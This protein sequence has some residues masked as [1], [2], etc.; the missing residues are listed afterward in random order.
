MAKFKKV[1]LEDMVQIASNISE[2]GQAVGIIFQN[3]EIS[4]GGYKRG[5]LVTTRVVSITIPI[6]ESDTDILV[7]QD[8]RGSVSVDQGAR[9]ILVAHLSGKTNLIDLPKHTCNHEDFQYSF[10]STLPAGVDYQ[11]TF[12]LLVERDSNDEDLGVHLVVDSLDIELGQ[13]DSGKK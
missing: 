10:D 12:F 9:A 11:A 3:L 5:P 6:A 1:L 4:L 13:P 7:Q 8:I 2:D